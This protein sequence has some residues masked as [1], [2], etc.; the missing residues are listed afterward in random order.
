MHKITEVQHVV[1]NG[2]NT[3]A[4]QNSWN[5]KDRQERWDGQAS[6]ETNM[7]GLETGF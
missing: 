1:V 5:K 4:T 6:D 3:Y 2:K 7:G